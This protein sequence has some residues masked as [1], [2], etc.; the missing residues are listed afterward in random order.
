[1]GDKSQYHSLSVGY[2]KFFID[3]RYINLKPCGD[4]SYGFVASAYDVIT[5][6]KIFYRTCYSD[7]G[8]KNNSGAYS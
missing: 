2:N 8:I 4:G 1:M 7:R 3:K 6:E 5:G